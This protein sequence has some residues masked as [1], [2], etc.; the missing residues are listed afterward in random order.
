MAFMVSVS[1]GQGRRKTNTTN[2][3]ITRERDQ[4][5]VAA[6]QANH[7]EII[8]LCLENARTKG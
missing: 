8:I 3:Y 4:K 6:E 5:L 1:T 2:T 7:R